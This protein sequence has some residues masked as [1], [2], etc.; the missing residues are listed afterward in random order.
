M[1]YVSPHLLSLPIIKS[2]LKLLSLFLRLLAQYI[3]KC[4]LFLRQAQ[5]SLY[6]IILGYPF[7]RFFV[8]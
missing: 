7:V 3:L 6:F 2:F 4:F 5:S 8:L 1:R